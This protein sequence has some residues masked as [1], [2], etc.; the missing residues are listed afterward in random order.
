MP[1]LNLIMGLPIKV[2]TSTSILIITI[3]DA[4]ASW[5]YLARGAILPIIVVPAV[6][7]MYLGSRV[8][9]AVAVKAKP[10]V[11]RCIFLAIM[12]FAAIMDIYKGLHGLGYV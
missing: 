12:F 2:S 7:G 1:V 5:V 8:G 4:T 3:T 11:I 6:L 9:A 10:K